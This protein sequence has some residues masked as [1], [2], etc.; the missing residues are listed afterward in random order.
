MSKRFEV[1]LQQDLAHL[2][3]SSLWVLLSFTVVTIKRSS[4][5][6]GRGLLGGGVGEE[7]R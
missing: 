6:W 7:G 5:G 1:C 3:I 2:H 4:A